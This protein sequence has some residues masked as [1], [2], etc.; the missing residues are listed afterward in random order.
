MFHWTFLRMIVPSCIMVCY[1][2]MDDKRIS[3]INCSPSMWWCFWITSSYVGTIK[4]IIG[5]LKLRSAIRPVTWPG[6]PSIMKALLFMSCIWL[7]EGCSLICMS[8]IID[9]FMSF[10]LSSLVS[11][12]CEM[13]IF[14]NMCYLCS[15]ILCVMCWNLF[16]L[17]GFVVK[18]L[19]VVS[20]LVL[21]SILPL[22][23]SLFLFGVHPLLLEFGSCW[24]WLLWQNFIQYFW[25]ILFQSWQELALLKIL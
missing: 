20:V 17:F 19:C 10:I 18:G 11:L 5:V 25:E 14:K 7:S 24:G 13:T 23:W 22:Y 9:N 21:W 1:I 12:V 6:W 3:P 2:M 15:G 8:F 16:A 4:D